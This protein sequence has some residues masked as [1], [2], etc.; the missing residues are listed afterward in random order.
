[1]QTYGTESIGMELMFGMQNLSKPASYHSDSFPA[2]FKLKEVFEE[3]YFVEVQLPGKIPKYLNQSVFPSMT[4]EDA[5]KELCK[6]DSSLN[7]N[8]CSMFRILDE[9]GTGSF[10]INNAASPQLSKL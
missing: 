1:M 8:S 4:I 10:N 2:Y 7:E 9:S 5:K 6:V 3:S